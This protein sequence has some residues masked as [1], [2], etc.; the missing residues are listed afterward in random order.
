MNTGC[1]RRHYEVIEHVCFLFLP[2]RMQRREQSGI[3]PAGAE[4]QV[5]QSCVLQADVLQDLPGPLTSHLPPTGCSK[6]GEEKK[7]RQRPFTEGGSSRG[8]DTDWPGRREK[9]GSAPSAAS[10]LLLQ[11]F[12]T[13]GSNRTAAQLAA[14]TRPFGFFFCS[15]HFFIL[16]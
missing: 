3:L 15:S 10:H 1:R 7:K 9:R 12:V 4:V 16:I 11:L 14:Q 13:G 8:S 5:L 6:P 2:A